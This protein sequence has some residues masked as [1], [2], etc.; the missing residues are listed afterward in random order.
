MDNHDK[1]IL[2]LCGGT[3]AWSRPYLEAGYDVRVI[4]WP[5]YDV[6]TYTP[7]ENVY[8]ILAAPPCT[9]FSL[10]KNGSHRKRDMAAGM[11][12]VEAC[13]YIIWQCRLQRGGLKF[14]ALENPRGYLRQLLGKP[15][16]CFEQWQYGDNGIKPTDIW[17][18]YNMPKATNDKRPDN[19]ALVKRYKTGATPGKCNTF[20]W[21]LPTPPGWLDITGLSRADLR[22]VTPQGFAQAFYRANK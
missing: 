17:G 18:Y 5:E 15:P 9:E 10:A 6:R 3:G 13:L 12:I 4:T 16:M 11:E 20:A 8:G 22:S 2:D 21:T 1:I 14:W 7:P 19:P